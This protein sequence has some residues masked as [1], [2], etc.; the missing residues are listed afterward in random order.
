LIP[1]K[2]GD[3]SAG[4]TWDPR[5]FNPKE[6][7]SIGERLK[8]HLCS[9]PIGRFMFADAEPVENDARMYSQ[10]PYCSEK[11]AGDGWVMVGDAAGF[12]DPLYSQGLDYCSHTVFAVHKIIG[13]SLE[14]SDVAADLARY[15][16]EFQTSYRRWFQA[17]YEDKYHYL[18][19]AELMWVA[20]LLDLATYFIGPVRLVHTNP[21]YEFTRLPYHGPIGRFFAWWMRQYNRRL[22]VI[23][24]RRHAAGRYGSWNLDRRLFIKQGFSPDAKVWKLLWRGLRAWAAVELK[25]ISLRPQPRT[26]AGTG[27]AAA[28]PAGHRSRSSACTAEITTV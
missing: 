18:G 7:G 21:E 10:L 9:D 15:E 27:V 11:V 16:R 23:A 26:D 12:M 6:G 13:R 14:G 22:A 17:L 19:D 3:L 25:S 24:R 1:L 8:C 5:I 4:I 2:G 28:S 20:F